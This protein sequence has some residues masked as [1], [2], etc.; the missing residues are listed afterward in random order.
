MVPKNRERDKKERNG[1]RKREGKK[2]GEGG[3]GKGQKKEKEG[4]APHPPCLTL[5]FLLIGTPTLCLSGHLLP[6]NPILPFTCLP[7]PDSS[8]ESASL[9]PTKSQ[10]KAE[11]LER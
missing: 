5:E 2:N 4:P 8:V 9:N 3:G 11:E 10:S 1:E 6:G 7:S